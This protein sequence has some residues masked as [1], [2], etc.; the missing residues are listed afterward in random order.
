[1]PEFNIIVEFDGIQH[2]EPIDF[3]GGKE[4]FI[5]QVRNDEIK[6]EYCLKNN[7][8][9]LRIPYWEFRNIESILSKELNL[10]FS[11]QDVCTERKEN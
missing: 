3:F 1:L 10:N 4:S 8:K 11:E 5:K 2:Y 6:N 7:I 9:L